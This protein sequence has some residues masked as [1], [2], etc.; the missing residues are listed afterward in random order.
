M[1]AGFRAYGMLYSYNKEPQRI[2]VV[3]FQSPVVEGQGQGL[4]RVLSLDF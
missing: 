2:I 3:V 1:K 4:Q